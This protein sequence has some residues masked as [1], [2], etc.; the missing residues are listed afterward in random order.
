MTTSVEVADFPLDFGVVNNRHPRRGISH[1]EA[2]H[3]FRGVEY[4]CTCSSL[5]RVRPDR[6]QE[7]RQEC[8]RLVP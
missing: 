5:I 4:Q 6:V 3:G 1:A 2:L 7:T 8:Q